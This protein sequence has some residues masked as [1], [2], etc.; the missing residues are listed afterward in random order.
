MNVLIS[1]CLVGCACRYDGKPAKNALSRELLYKLSEKYTLIPVCPEVL[2]GL[3]VPRSPS[4][5]QSDGSVKNM[6]GEDVTDAFKRGAEAALAIAK[7]LS[8]GIAVLKS[9][10]P[11]CGKKS[12]YDGSFSGRLIIGN[13]FTAELLLKN[14]IRV[15][16]EDEIDTLL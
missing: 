14:G 12:I 10:S 9:K 16:T 7:E 4:E 6:D 15:I 3:S 5:I 11:S 13:G 1:S 2:S 8:C